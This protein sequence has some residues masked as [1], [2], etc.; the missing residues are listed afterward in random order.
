[1]I[2]QI[3][4]RL[5]GPV[6]Q[7]IGPDSMPP[8]GGDQAG[9]FAGLM[10]Q[11]G[12]SHPNLVKGGEGL[13][14]E[15]P[16]DNSVSEG[17]VSSAAF[18]LP[19]SMPQL[20]RV[21]DPLQVG[22]APEVPI[23]PARAGSQMDGPQE[24]LELQLSIS[25]TQ[26]LATPVGDVPNKV[27]AEL[28]D[29]VLPAQGQPGWGAE[30]K[31][32]IMLDAGAL[33]QMTSPADMADFDVA[34]LENPR[35]APSSAATQLF[36]QAS[37]KDTAAQGVPMQQTAQF[38]MA[39]MAAAFS[40]VASDVQALVPTAEAGGQNRPQGLGLQASPISAQQTMRLLAPDAQISIES[41]AALQVQN[42]TQPVLARA[43]PPAAGTA[44]AALQAFAQGASAA[45]GG[46]DV[47]ADSVDALVETAPIQSPVARNMAAIYATSAQ[48]GAQMSAAFGGQWLDGAVD[49]G[50]LSF[51]DA[52]LGSLGI[53][54]GRSALPPL[55]TAAAPANTSLAGQ[56]TSAAQ[57]TA[58][59]L[60][61]ATA[62]QS[63]PVEL[64]LSP[65]ELGNLRFEIHQ[66][67]EQL[68]IVLSAE[69][70]ETLDLL[71]RNGEQLLS[72]FR[73]AGFTGASLSFGGWGAGQNNGANPQAFASQ[74][75]DQG[76]TG[77][78]TAAFAAQTAQNTG[79]APP[80]SYLDPS[81]SLNLRL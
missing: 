3:M 56:T 33:A 61:L 80:T 10:T 67:G 78:A 54:E 14:G 75:Q 37:L 16:I 60:P 71:R 47:A 30:R 24:Y 53:G 9:A 21:S 48:H 1:M 7:G 73:N 36:G 81:R 42:L 50:D 52:T 39:D 13:A 63:G 66:R 72:D 31:G 20:L 68:Q 77:P 25:S 12:V 69:R 58:Q 6:L 19:A 15:Q 62:A 44:I 51:G 22:Q 76:E 34:L 32:A 43:K 45:K 8:M 4:Q 46:A 35:V 28:G 11:E 17:G 27:S 65:A 40:A 5:F 59:I 49:A 29:I 38:Q 74:A 26:D 2:A 70:P 55:S 57:I 79:F 23:A 18:V 41:A 64:V